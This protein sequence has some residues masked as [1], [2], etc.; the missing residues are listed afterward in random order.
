M[1]RWNL[2]FA[3]LMGLPLV[4]ISVLGLV[5][6]DAVDP[7]LGIPIIY[8]IAF[9]MVLA[10]QMF[11]GSYTMEMIKQDLFSE[12]KWRMHA[13]PSPVQGYAFAVLLTCTVFS[14]LQGF[15]LVLYTR[16]VYGVNWGN[17]GLVLLLMLAISLVSNLVCLLLVMSVKE[18]SMAERL[19]EVYGLG[20]IAIA[21]VW[22][23]I[24]QG[25]LDIWI[26][27]F[28]HNYGN[29]VSL[30][31]N[32]IY[33]FLPGGDTQRAFI[34]FAILVA[35]AALLAVCAVFVGRRKLA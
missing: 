30:G 5:A 32:V 28:L 8:S 31:L 27:G 33:G 6:G 25:L 26:I 23:P 13:L 11:G 4:L 34:S 14:A 17:L 1:L 35:A 15:L 19:S 29:P 16:Y 10:F 18:Y 22:F 7:N 3:I 20:S 24:P 12:R 21:G 2:A 9:M